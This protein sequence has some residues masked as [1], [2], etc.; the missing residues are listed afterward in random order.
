MSSIPFASSV[1]NESMPTN[2]KTK[3]CCALKKY[4]T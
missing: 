2:I 1:S 4:N 3:P